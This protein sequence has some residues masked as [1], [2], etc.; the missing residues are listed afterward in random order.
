MIA[1]DAETMLWFFPHH[2][3]IREPDA[4]Y[5]AITA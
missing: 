2:W 5:S 4:R 1:L 3:T